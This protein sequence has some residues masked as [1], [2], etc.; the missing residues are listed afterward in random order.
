MRTFGSILVTFITLTC[1]RVEAPRTPATDH[2]ATD[3]GAIAVRPISATCPT[4][5]PLV[6]GGQLG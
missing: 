4:C 2:G 6:A 5:R 1:A 3:H